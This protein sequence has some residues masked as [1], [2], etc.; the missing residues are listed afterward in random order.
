[1]ITINKSGE[2]FYVR[3]ESVGRGWII[4]EMEKNPYSAKQWE[5]LHSGKIDFLNPDM[6]QGVYSMIHGG[7]NDFGQFSLHLDM[8]F[9]NDSMIHLSAADSEKFIREV[10]AISK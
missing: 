5:D 4:W 2:G 7:T 10:I 9:G 1:M 8:G 3:I 6:G